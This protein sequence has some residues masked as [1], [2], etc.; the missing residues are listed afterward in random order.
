MSRFR[1]WYTGQKSNSH[2]TIK[3]GH[4]HWLLSVL[5][6]AQSVLEVYGGGGMM[7]AGVWQPASICATSTDGDALDWL[8][9]HDTEKTICTT[10]PARQSQRIDEENEGARHEHGARPSSA[11]AACTASG[12]QPSARAVVASRCQT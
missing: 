2:P 9:S 3:L 7:F 8:N 6:E 4:R 12:I 1:V 10:E 11:F 5:P